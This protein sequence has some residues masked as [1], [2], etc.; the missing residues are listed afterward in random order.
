MGIFFYKP[1]TPGTRHRSNS[2]FKE[3]VR[4]NRIKSPKSL[5]TNFKKSFG[6]NN[7]GVITSP[8]RS[9]GHKRLYR[10]IDFQ[11]NKYKILAEVVSVEYDPNRNAR[12][13]LLHYEDGQKRYI[14]NPRGLQPK[15]QVVADLT[16]PI[17]I[18]NALPL[19]NIPLGYEIHNIE[20]QPGCGGQL[21][22]SAGTLA[23]LVSKEENFVSIRL[24][25]GE[26]RYLSNKCWATI[27]QVG[28]NE[29]MSV[30]IGKAGRKRWL[31]RRPHV[32]GSAM[33]PCDH[34]H[35]CCE[36]RAPVGRA[37]PVTP[38]GKAT[39]GKKTRKPKRYSNK[40][41]IRRP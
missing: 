22:R 1:N 8:H 19:I 34:P 7:R 3:L 27:G 40:Q 25:S 21:V 20:L 28:H 4:L 38:W 33:N 32:R 12:I 5:K 39:L 10:K 13:S 35:G 9:Q 41:I 2:D 18:G 17:Q 14:L 6:R 24:P 30:K 23:R 26:I 36:G 29:A 31:G 16:S 37:Q 15:D 11:R